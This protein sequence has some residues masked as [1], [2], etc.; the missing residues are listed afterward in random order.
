METNILEGQRK[1][2]NKNKE[3]SGHSLNINNSNP[4]Y[5]VEVLPNLMMGI[6][7]HTKRYIKELKYV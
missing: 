2:P 1:L 3:I 4:K 6:C 7:Q 5:T